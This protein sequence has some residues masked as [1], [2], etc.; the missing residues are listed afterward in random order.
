MSFGMPTD[1]TP[2]TLSSMDGLTFAFTLD[3]TGEVVVAKFDSA[4]QGHEFVANT[5][6]TFD[7][8][9]SAAAV[10]VGDDA[11]PFPKRPATRRTCTYRE[12]D[13]RTRGHNQHYIPVLRAMNQKFCWFPIDILAH[14]GTTLTFR[15][16]TPLGDDTITAHNHNPEDLALAQEYNPDWKILR[17][18]VDGG[19]YRAILLSDQPV[20][21]CT[22]KA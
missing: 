4:A 21:A 7:Y 17:Y 14:D 8:S 5:G 3:E 18:T 9:P 1:W 15:V 6:A 19:G 13:Q 10:R 12:C 16:S 20:T 2:A 11:V 22:T